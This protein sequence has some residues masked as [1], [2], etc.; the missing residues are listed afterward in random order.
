MKTLYMTVFLWRV[1]MCK[2]LVQIIF[3]EKLLHNFSRKTLVVVVSD[4]DVYF[5]VQTVV[6]L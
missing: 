4:F 5:L 6:G 3:L 1:W 2:D